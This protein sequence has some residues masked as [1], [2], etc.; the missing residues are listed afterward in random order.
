MGEP[1]LDIGFPKGA[2][3]KARRYTEQTGVDGNGCDTVTS[4]ATKKALSELLPVQGNLDPLV[5]I[6]GWPAK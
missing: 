3:S 6:V 1:P 5:L 2:S 4:V